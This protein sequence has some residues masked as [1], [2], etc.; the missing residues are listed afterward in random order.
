M[1]GL[2]QQ[3]GAWGS[4][5]GFIL[6]AA[7]S[8]VGLGNIWKFPYVTGN[9]GGGLFL[10][11]YL[12]CVVVVGLPIMN[13][14]IIMGRAT[15]SS[16]VGA[17]RSLA[18]RRS[19]W[20][21]T[22]WLG[23]V[24]GF[25]ILS[26]YS[27]VAGWA[28]YYAGISIFEGF[29]DGSAADLKA[30]SAIFT[31]LVGDAPLNV[32]LHAGFMVA[33]VAVVIGGV[34]SGIERWSRILMPALFVMLIGLCVY[35]LS[36]PGAGKAL[37]FM[38]G[39]HTDQLR[40]AGF[41]EAFGQAFFSL[42]LGMGAM[43]TYG[44]YLP[45]KTSILGSS[46]WVAL[47]DTFVALLASIVIFPVTFTYGIEP[48]AGPGLVF[49][50]LPV[51][52]AQM[53]GG[54][55]IAAAFFV[56]LVFAA[57]TSS[58]SLL[59]VVASTFIDLLG[60]SR[61]KAVLVTSVAIFF[62]GVPSA[63]SGGSLFGARMK[64]S[65][66]MTFFD[67]MDNLSSNWMLPLGGLMIAFFVGWRMHRSTREEQFLAETPAWTMSPWLALLRFVAPVAVLLVMAKSTGVFRLLGLE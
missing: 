10:L 64:Q 37:N 41:L 24:A 15:A 19:P 47:L 67:L 51:A 53:S 6:A 20:T 40:P 63:L 28:V 60:W 5:V 22:G 12:F 44:S 43:L 34:Q 35:S 32:S 26:F 65:L 59:E 21:L 38:F 54:R 7:G 13:A 36:L 42:S 46:I 25:V 2:T 11:I 61:S 30:I 49:Q 31:H 62:V 56:L 18:G 27:V 45:A 58:I 23:V 57:L 33:T 14:E 8:A 48:S 50:S 17:F 16:P 39:L 4:R 9:N 3:R 52:F 66:G 55:V 29:G 1:A